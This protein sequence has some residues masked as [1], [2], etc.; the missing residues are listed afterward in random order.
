MLY[1]P[2]QVTKATKAAK[3]SEPMAVLDVLSVIRQ[4]ISIAE[5]GAFSHLTIEKD[6]VILIMPVILRP[7][8][9]QVNIIL[10]DAIPIIY[11]FH[12]WNVKK[13]SHN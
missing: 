8:E 9:L 6:L 7:S 5:C 10:L 12:Y 4:H 3:L 2:S 13:L 11:L 1:S